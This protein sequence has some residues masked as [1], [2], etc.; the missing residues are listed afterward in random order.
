MDGADKVLVINCRG[1]CPPPNAQFAYVDPRDV[2]PSSKWPK[3]TPSPIACF[4]PTKGR[5]SR[6]ISSL[7]QEPPHPLRPSDLF[8]AENPGGPKGATGDTGCTGL[9]GETVAMIDP[10]GNESHLLVSLL[11]ASH[12]ARLA[13]WQEHWLAILHALPWNYMGLS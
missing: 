10:A 13:R 5:V 4:R 7:F 3:P 8:A 1:I 12:L 2:A 11:R 9:P 6:H